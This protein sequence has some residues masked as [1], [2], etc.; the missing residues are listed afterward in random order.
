MYRAAAP[1][2]MFGAQAASNGEISPPAPTAPK[3]LNIVQ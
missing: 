3:T 2:R 1:K